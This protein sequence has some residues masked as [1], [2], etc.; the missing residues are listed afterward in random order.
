MTGAMR[1]FFFFALEP[2]YYYDGTQGTLL[3]PIPE[4]LRGDFS[5]VVAVNGG[6]APRAVAEK[7]A[8]Q[9]QVRDA[10]L[11]NQYTV[12]GQQFSRITL[13]AS[14]SYPVFP[15]NVIPQ[16]MLDPTSVSL[17]QYVPKAGEYFLDGGNLRNYVIP[18]F[19]KNLEKRMTLRLDHQLADS[20][21]SRTR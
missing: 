17:L 6:Y 15:N 13:A 14:A 5:N 9:T 7:F 16:N 20:R 2:R 3:L 10:T 4:M 8:L 18:S 11:Y 12:S 1:S 21:R 19:I